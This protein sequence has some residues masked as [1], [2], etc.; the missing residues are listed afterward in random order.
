MRACM[1]VFRRPV[2]EG[3]IQLAMLLGSGGEADFLESGLWGRAEVREG[4]LSMGT[5]WFH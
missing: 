2:E 4:A 5:L 1:C 3:S